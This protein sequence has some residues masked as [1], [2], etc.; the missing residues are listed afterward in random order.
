MAV[1]R[2][3]TFCFSAGPSSQPGAEVV[4]KCRSVSFVGAEPD[5]AGSRDAGRAVAG[6]PPPGWRR[7]RPPLARGFRRQALRLHRRG[8][9]A[10]AYRIKDGELLWQTDTG[11]VRQKPRSFEWDRSSRH[12]V[13]GYAVAGLYV[14][15]GPETDRCAVLSQEDGHSMWHL[16]RGSGPVGPIPL[17]FEDLVWVDENALDPD[18]GEVR[19]KVS[20][21]R[22]GCSRFTAAP[23]GIFG[24]EGL[25]W[26]AIV[27]AEHPVIPAKSGCGAG[28]YVANGLVW[29][30]PTPCS[31]CMEWRGFIP[32][33]A[34]EQE[35]PAAGPRLVP[36]TQHNPHAAR[37]EGWTTYR[38][39]A[40]RSASIAAEVGQHVHISWHFSSADRT[41]PVADFQ[42]TLLAPGASPR[43]ARHRRQHGRRRRCRWGRPVDR[44]AD[45]S[46]SLVRLHR[47][48]DLQQSDDLEGSR[49]R[50][51][52]PTATCTPSPS[53]MVGNCGGC[54]SRPRQDG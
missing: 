3:D 29:K 18:T 27:G 22:G 37:T 48:A 4:G 41:G 42:Q 36:G 7:L 21:N 47:R 38:G 6:M 30:F 12:P 25:T 32:R 50:R 2:S 17:A 43:A 39:N 31:A 53:T 19:R 49:V 10:E 1:D 24:T 40:S 13:T 28:Q 51:V 8:D 33:A 35:L 34:A 46:A 26:N 23:Q 54:E 45:G 44:L 9:E 16:P 5:G 11:I 14:V 52:A 15:S 20:L